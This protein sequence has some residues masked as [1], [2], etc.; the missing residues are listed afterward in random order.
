MALDRVNCACLSQHKKVQD[1]LRQVFFLHTDF[2]EHSSHGKNP[3]W[4]AFE[5]ESFNTIGWSRQVFLQGE[6]EVDLTRCWGECKCTVCMRVTFNVADCWDWCVIVLGLSFARQ[7]GLLCLLRRLGLG[8]VKLLALF[9]LMWS[10][11]GLC[12]VG[13]KSGWRPCGFCWKKVLYGSLLCIKDVTA[14]V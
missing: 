5:G 8:W 2:S 13:I 4:W 14:R 7:W 6:N 1:V 10:L 12:L 11:F 9:S 3:G